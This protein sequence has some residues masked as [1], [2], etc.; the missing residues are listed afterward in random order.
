M[1]RDPG[2]TPASSA[3]DLANSA[4]GRVD[5]LPP[6]SAGRLRRKM[7]TAEKPACKAHLGRLERLLADGTLLLADPNSAR[8]SPASCSSQH[9][10][11]RRP[12]KS[13]GKI[14][15]FVAAWRAAS[16]ARCASRGAEVTTTNR[17]RTAPC[18]APADPPTA[19]QGRRPLDRG[20]SSAGR[21]R[22]SRTRRRSARRRPG[23]DRPPPA[24]RPARPGRARRPPRRRQPLT[25][26]RRS[27]RTR[28]PC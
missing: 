19:P 4:D 10:R 27:R 16:S 14:Q 5:P 18:G 22:R 24:R 6:L 26:A 8:R 15:G 17:Q 12:G 20:V 9:P 11:S 13:W 3:R 28:R 21:A 7:T 25:P 23:A 1:S 2:R